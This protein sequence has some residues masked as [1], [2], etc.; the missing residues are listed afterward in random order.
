MRVARCPNSP[1][2]SLNPTNSTANS[3]SDQI[4]LLAD[5][6]E[7]DH[8]HQQNPDDF[9]GSRHVECFPVELE[10]FRQRAHRLIGPNEVHG[11]GTGSIITV[12]A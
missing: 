6:F 9:E 12:V 3:D 8:R 10:Y 7:H 5:H 4:L 2:G 11:R 1:P